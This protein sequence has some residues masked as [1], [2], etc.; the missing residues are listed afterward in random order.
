MSNGPSTQYFPSSDFRDFLFQIQRGIV[1][2]YTYEE[3]N[4][5]TSELSISFFGTVWNANP[6]SM[7]KYLAAAQTVQL[8]STSANDATA[9]TGARSVKVKGLDGNYDLIEEVVTMNGQTPV[10]TTNQFFR[11][12]NLDV[13]TY[14]TL[15]RNAGDIYLGSGTVTSGVNNIVHGFIFRNSSYSSMGVY[16]VPRGYTLIA[17]DAEYSVAA[18]KQASVRTVVRPS[19]SDPFMQINVGYLFA[20]PSTPEFDIT[21]ATISEK[22]DIEIQAI[23]NVPNTSMGG[24]YQIALVDN[25]YL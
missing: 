12:L 15:S 20:G 21:T 8:S 1:P 17:F 14:G 13:S 19:P 7:Y 3:R 23:G 9:G 18:G 5:F 10:T 16:T 24:N 25:K 4:V 22:T 11:I 2:G 6:P